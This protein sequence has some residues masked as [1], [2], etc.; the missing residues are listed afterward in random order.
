[1]SPSSSSSRSSAS[2]PPSC[3][4]WYACGPTV[5]DDA[6]IGHARTYINT[7]IIRRILTDHFQVNVNFAMGMTD[8][9][10]KIIQRSKVQKISNTKPLESE[11]LPNWLKLAR[12]YEASFLADM[13]ALNVRR[14]VVILRVTEHM[15]EI[16]RYISTILAEDKAYVT[17]SG[18]YFSVARHSSP[19]NEY[20]KLGPIPTSSSNEHDVDS[21]DQ[22][23][24]FGDKK[25]PRDFALWK[26]VK[27]SGSGSGDDE[28]P[29]W[30]SP[31]GKGR[32]G[33]H[34]ECSA[35]T[36]SHF[37]ES[38]DIHSGGIDLRFPHHTNEIAQW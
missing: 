20:G 33:W 11:E 6:H 16:K 21:D 26:R 29:F 35:V 37:G 10:D 7:D 18:V 12:K 34:I 4:S 1:M 17:P 22:M 3:L 24:L 19:S 5:Y 36:H 2:P 14:P 13:D 30:D 8:I 23:R 15:E 27:D 25:D 32:P 28:E 38:L 31:W 9:D